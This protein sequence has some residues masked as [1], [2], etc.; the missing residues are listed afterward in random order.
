MVTGSLSRR[1][2][3]AL[4]E[5]G[6]SNGNLDKLGQDLRNL[7]TAMKSSS[8]LVDL[9][10]N[11]VIQRSDR[12]RVLQA[13]LARF[14]AHEHS[15]NLVNILL[16]GERMSYVSAISRELD[17]MIDVRAGKIAAEVTSATTLS[18]V[19]L[20]SITSAL[21]RLSGKTVTITKREDPTILGGVIAKLG[22]VIYDGSIRSQLRTMRDDLTK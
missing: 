21:E 22:D 12:K 18:A 8:E 14:D 17:A 3:R 10:N 16:D 5:L 20:A 13:I 7:S 19:Q 4:F 1:Y 2:A 6:T 11:P 9:L 15:K